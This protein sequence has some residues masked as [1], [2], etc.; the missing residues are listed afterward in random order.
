M[1][2]SEYRRGRIAREHFATKMRPMV[3]SQRFQRLLLCLCMMQG[4]ADRPKYIRVHHEGQA[5]VQ[6]GERG[7]GMSFQR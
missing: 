2:R 3:K 1:S 4:G 6:Y 5:T 7:I